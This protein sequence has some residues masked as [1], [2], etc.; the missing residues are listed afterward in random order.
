MEE[1]RTIQIKFGGFLSMLQIAFIVLKLCGVIG[2][3]WWT[4]FLPT[5][6]P[7]GI[8]LFLLLIVGILVFISYLKNVNE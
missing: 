5:I 6:I 7:W 2:W 8:I 3:S 1:K 4:V